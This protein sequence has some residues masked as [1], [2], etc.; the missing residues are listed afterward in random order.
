MISS[1]KKACT[2]GRFLTWRVIGCNVLRHFNKRFCSWLCLQNFKKQSKINV[3]ITKL[4]S[5]YIKKAVNRQ[6]FP[7]QSRRKF[8]KVERNEN[9][10]RKNRH[11]GIPGLLTQVLD[12]GLWTLDSGHWT[13]DARLWTVDAGLWTLD[14]ECWTL[15]AELWMLDSGC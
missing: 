5:W 9:I 4:M 15:D 3:C 7:L 10:L 1:Y 2:S 11:T 14:Y 6:D 8:L 13:L 12:S